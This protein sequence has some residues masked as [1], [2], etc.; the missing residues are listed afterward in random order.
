MQYG[1]SFNI[2]LYLS[3]VLPELSLKDSSPFR[4][5]LPSLHHFIIKID[6]LFIHSFI[7]SKS[8]FHFW[9][10]LVLG[11]WMVDIK[12]VLRIAQSNQ[13]IRETVL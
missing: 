4:K 9:K 2:V 8:D 5:D 10:S 11:G 1:Q 13:K 6:K 3:V 7:Q 12:A